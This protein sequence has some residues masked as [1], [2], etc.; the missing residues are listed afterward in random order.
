MQDTSCE[1]GYT[2]PGFPRCQFNI[3]FGGGMM[4][5]MCAVICQDNAGG[6]LLCPD[7]AT[8]CNGTCPGMLRCIYDVKNAQMDV[9]G[10][11]CL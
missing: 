6:P 3:D 4:Q 8:Q 11:A 2:G 7:G 10:K 9:V 1:D 5:T